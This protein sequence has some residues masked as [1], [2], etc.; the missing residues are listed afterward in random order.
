[1]SA[2]AVQVD[3]IDEEQRDML[4]LAYHYPISTATTTHT[5]NAAPTVKKT[6]KKKGHIRVSVYY[7]EYIIRSVFLCIRVYSVHVSVLLFNVHSVAMY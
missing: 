6:I 3:D 2:P 5:L 1:M 7:Q 4:S